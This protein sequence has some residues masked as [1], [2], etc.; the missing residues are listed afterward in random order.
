MAKNRNNNI[1]VAEEDDVLLYDLEWL[2]EGEQFPPANQKAR[3]D[4]YKKNKAL[5]ETKHKKTYEDALVRI[6]SII[7][8]SR[9][10]IINPVVLNYN[11][12]LSVKTADL[13]CGEEPT[14]KSDKK[15]V[16]NIID[17]ILDTTNLTTTILYETV[18]DISRY[19]D[20]VWRI[21]KNE[22]GKGDITIWDPKEWFPIV[23]IDNPKKIVNHVLAWKVYK[24]RNMHGEKKY[25]LHA[26]IHY[27]GYYE[28]LV[29]DM[30]NDKTIGKKL[31]TEKV[32]T[33]TKDFAVIH[34]SNVTTSDSPFGH[35]DY[36]PVDSIISE[37]MIRFGQI[38]NIL[39]KHASPSLQG[40]LTALEYDE[41]SRSYRLKLANYFAK[42]PEDE[43]VKYLTWD[44]NLD[45]AFQEIEKLI[46]QLLIISEMGSALLGSVDSSGRAVSGTTMK[47]RMM[48]PLMKAR[49][50]VKNLHKGLIEALVGI[51]QIG[52]QQLTKDDFS[53]EWYDGLPDDPM[54]EAQIYAIR[55][56]QKP[57]ISQKRAIMAMDDLN[58]KQAEEV[59]EEI[60]QESQNAFIDF[61]G[62][63]MP[64]N[65]EQNEGENESGAEE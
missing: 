7:G 18:I 59:L 24:G 16:Q 28:H 65:E 8:D 22:E 12:L 3:L 10:A 43:E 46:D 45:A 14:I 39:D 21:Y 56:G 49:R 38:Q 52:Y 51:S 50:L 1:V 62:I 41:R 37:L 23:S 61:M 11:K 48:N 25:E 32:N 27:K 35:D 19:G 17:E 57:T 29:F 36:I 44:G 15:D 55:T 60:N 6:Q 34:I 30:K 26:Q 63:D 5:F 58:E 20:A 9:R 13:C 33:G 31:S 53:I 40:P 64:R 54:E 4:R 42:N 47:L 2:K